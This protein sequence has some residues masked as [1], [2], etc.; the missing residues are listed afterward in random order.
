MVKVRI[1]CGACGFSTTV[2]ADK[3]EE[4]EVQITL[5]SECERVRRMSDDISTLTMMAA[6]TGFL[7][8]PVY[9]SAAKHLPHVAC[10]V[11][12]GILKALEVELGFNVPKDASIR[13]LED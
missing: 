4:K 7:S 8:N 10:P 1:H 9:R 11:P 12:S 5:E 6:F 2:T 13:F 3:R